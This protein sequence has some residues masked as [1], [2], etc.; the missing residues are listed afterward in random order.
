MCSLSNIRGNYGTGTNRSSQ[1]RSLCITESERQAVYKKIN[2]L[3]MA[4]V[5][6][7]H[8]QKNGSIKV[9]NEKKELDIEQIRE[10][11]QEHGI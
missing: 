3:R 4:L 9:Q 5:N 10:Y 7:S 1:K 6:Q 2:Q 8:I 11:F